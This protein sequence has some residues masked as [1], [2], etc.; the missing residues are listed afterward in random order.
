MNTL[1]KP[2]SLGI[3]SLLFTLSL[4]SFNASGDELCYSVYNI[5]QDLNLTMNYGATEQR[6]TINVDID[7]HVKELAMSPAQVTYFNALG[8]DA[9]RSFIFLAQA[10]NPKTIPVATNTN[11]RYQHPFMVI[12]NANSGELISIKSTEDDNAAL[13]EYRSFYDLFQYSKNKG[14][15][16]Y[17]NGNGRYTASI[18]TQAGQ[19]I[20]TNLGYTKKGNNASMVSIEKHFL[21]ILLDQKGGECFYQKSHG[22]EHF[23][24]VLSPNAFVAGNAS[25][26]VT[27]Q[28]SN[29]LPAS[30]V[31]YSLTDNLLAW[32]SYKKAVVM[33][34]EQ[35]LD[36]IPNFLVGLAATLDDKDQFIAMM[37]QQQALWP[38]LA[39]HIQTGQL[40]DKL[41]LTLFWALDKINT[42]GSVHALVNLTTSD[43]TTRD[44]F[45]A[46][47]ALSSTSA[48]FNQNDIALLTSQFSSFGYNEQIQTNELMYMRMLGAMAS[49]RH[50]TDPAHSMEIKQFLYSQVDSF[51][52]KVNAAVISAIGNL[53][54]SIDS[55]G[56]SILISSLAADSEQVRVSA[57]SAFKRVP[58]K[59]EHGEQFIDR[60]GNEPSNKVR[61]NLIIA[62]GRASH[63]EITVKQK[64]I[65]ELDNPVLDQNAL[66]SL[67]KVGFTFANEDITV[68]ENK[69][70]NEPNR[71]N[72]R[73][74]AS[75]ILKHRSQQER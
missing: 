39:E 52:P 56:E 38:Y 15:Y 6:Q 17:Q 45:R 42:M 16:H 72:Q 2:I 8:V 48:P 21:N 43:L 47:L 55:E 63:S 67:K 49:R 19:L 35:A 60:L 23:K 44:Q 74:L 64:L 22:K 41:S 61:K 34:A 40:S 18:D 65:A 69:L 25:V 4:L 32:P 58:Y 46:V 54:D 28:P 51:D 29:A 14:E 20:K 70:R 12:V 36:K 26:T 11:H 31:F 53:K 24:T 50:V 57:S 3:P 66:T 37:L 10:N 59:P 5:Q 68:L 30:H 71:V 27:A 1:L 13:N 9:V 75:L 7:L 33:S 73:L 62:L